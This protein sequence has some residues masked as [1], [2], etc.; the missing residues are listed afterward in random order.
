MIKELIERESNCRIRRTDS[1]IRVVSVWKSLPASIVN[2]STVPLALL[3]DY[4]GV[5]TYLDLHTAV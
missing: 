4:F 2:F 5:L 3:N 1:R